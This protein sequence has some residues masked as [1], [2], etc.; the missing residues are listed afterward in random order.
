MAGKLDNVI[1]DGLNRKDESLLEFSFA[2]F[3]HKSRNYTS[4]TQHLIKANK[5]KLTFYP[6]NLG[7]Q[8]LL[9]E[10][11]IELTKHVNIGDP[12]DGEGRIFIIGAPRCGSTLLESVL[13]TDS[14]IRELGESLGL[15]LALAQIKDTISAKEISPSLSEAYAENTKE[16]LSKYSHSV[17]KNLYNF[18][19]TEAILRGMPS[20]RVIHC[21]RHPLDN[22][23]SMLRSNLR[24]GNN[25]TSD[26][27]EAAKFLIHQEQTINRL[28]TKYKKNIFTFDYDRFTSNP[29]KTLRPL[30]DW[31]GL[32]WNEKYLHPE[33]NDRVINTASF[34]QA[35]QPINS[36]SVGGW[37]NYRRL[38]KYAERILRESD[39]FDL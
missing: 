2:N 26:P 5:L 9:T 14:N 15:S 27:I 17:D 29:E 24:C 1:R 34:F 20:A 39:L 30:T 10:Q 33:T 38:L 11:A 13:S 37:K 6:S 23:L 21:R 19:F 35:R 7:K 32:K 25:Y 22:I 36:N 8:I 31:L 28:K 12:S 4:A 16:N 18:R 3:H